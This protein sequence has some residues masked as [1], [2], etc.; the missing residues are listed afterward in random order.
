MYPIFRQQV[1]KS[2]KAYFPSE[3]I[4]GLQAEAGTLTQVPNLFNAEDKTAIME[5]SKKFV[6]VKYY[7]EIWHTNHFVCK[8]KALHGLLLHLDMHHL[9]GLR[10]CSTSSRVQWPS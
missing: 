7:G 2:V 3:H 9:S 10:G 1:C 4:H 6:G 5:A 8:V